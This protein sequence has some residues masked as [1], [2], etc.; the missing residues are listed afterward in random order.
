MKHLHVALAA[1]ALLSLCACAV[2]PVPTA[3]S[4]ILTTEAQLTTDDQPTTEEALTV[5][6]FDP[7]FFRALL[8]NGYESPDRL[9]RVRLLTSPFRVYMRTLDDGG[10]AIPSAT[11]AATERVLIES[12]SV[13]SGG[14]FGITGVVRGTGSRENTPGWLTVKWSSSAGTGRCGLSSVGVDGGVIQLNS[15]GEC[16]CG[17]PTLVYPRVVRHELGHAMGYY[18][19]DNFNDVMYGKPITSAA[20]DA[21]PSD[22]ERLH[23]RF[24]HNPG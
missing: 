8:Q 24:A 9:E 16:S 17:L 7:V 20:C 4:A 22:R 1:G 11:L 14:R 23:T 5:D 2:V 15:S 6:E 13:W 3:P 19:T 21:Q 12:A 18:H 10:R